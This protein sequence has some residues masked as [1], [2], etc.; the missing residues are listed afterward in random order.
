MVGWHHQLNG[1][2]FEQAPGDGEGQG[3]LV[4]CNPWSCKESDTTERLNNNNKW[5]KKKEES[6]IEIIIYQSNK[7]INTQRNEC[8]NTNHQSQLI[9][10]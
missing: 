8:L 9:K 2:V 4:F 7:F 10:S 3:S 5:I 1:Y 6:F